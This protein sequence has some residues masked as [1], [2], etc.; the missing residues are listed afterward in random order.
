[1]TERKPATVSFGDWV[2]NQIRRAE[3]DGAFAGLPGAGKPL[4]LPDHQV[5]SMMAWVAKKLHDEAA[6]PAAFLPPQILIAREVE[7]IPEHI[8]RYRT[9]AEV[10]AYLDDLNERIIAIWALP[11][12]GPAMRTKL[13]KPEDIVASWR[14]WRESVAADSVRASVAVE[15]APPR[16][17][18]FWRR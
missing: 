8:G 2:E 12:S 6:D 13:V 17:R 4:E 14:A 1:M 7:Q 3:R 10:R 18:R 9:E 5:D 11:P 16:R 15:P